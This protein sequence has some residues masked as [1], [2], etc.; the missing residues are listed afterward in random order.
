MNSEDLQELFSQLQKEVLLNLETELEEMK[1]K[2]KEEID[3]YL[4]ARKEGFVNTVRTQSVQ[5][6]PPKTQ[7]QVIVNG[8]VIK[9][10]NSSDNPAIDGKLLSEQIINNVWEQLAKANIH[11][12]KEKENKNEKE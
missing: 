8:E 4:S 1:K 2:F 12:K 6:N 3:T 11:K 10:E 9:G 7:S 5:Y